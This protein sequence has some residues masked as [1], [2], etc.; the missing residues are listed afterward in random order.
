ELE[1][2]YLAVFAPLPER[3]EHASNKIT[4]EKVALG[5]KLYHDTR[6]SAS[7]TLSCA[8]CHNLK[9]Y[10][11]DHNPASEG[12][13]GQFGKPNSPTVYNAALAIA[14]FWDGRAPDVEEQALGPV[15]NPVEMAMGSETDVLTVLKDDGDYASAFKAVFPEDAEPIN[16]KNFGKA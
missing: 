10:G 13:K 5:K 2:R 6:V 7:R 9:T 12:H 14:E 16:F 3:A 11:A 8:S 4:P 15:M 1:A